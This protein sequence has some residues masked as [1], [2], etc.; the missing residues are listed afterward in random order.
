MSLI[1]Y[2]I[3]ALQIEEQHEEMVQDLEKSQF[4]V[5]CIFDSILTL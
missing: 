3:S 1:L 5:W 2:I 4:M